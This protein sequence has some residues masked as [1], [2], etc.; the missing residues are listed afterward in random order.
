MNN[1]FMIGFA[2]LVTAMILYAFGICI[3]SAKD[4]LISL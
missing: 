1:T 2:I 3:I 4:L